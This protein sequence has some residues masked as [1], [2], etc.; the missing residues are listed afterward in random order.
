MLRRLLDVRRE[1]RRL[2][3]T[4]FLVLFGILAAHTILETARDALFLARLPPSQLPW[5]YLAMAAIAVTLSNWSTRRLHG[6]RALASL[7]AICSAGT[8][9]FWATGSPLGSWA[10]RALYV[11]TGLVSTLA[12]V[13]FWLVVS[14]LY[15]ITQAKRVYAVIGLGSLLGAVAGGGVAR[16]V[17][18]RVGA[19]HLLLVS[20]A[21]LAATAFGPATRLG[22]RGAT[23]GDDRAATGPALADGL[24]LIWRHPYLARLAGIVLIATL[25]VTLADYVFKSAVARAVPPAQLASFFASFYTVLNGLALAAQLFVVSWLMRVLGVNRALWVLPAFLFL[26][27]T[28][29]VGGGG[30]VA[31]LLLKGADGVLRPSL[32]RVGMELLFVPVPDHLRSF[33]K[34]TD[35]LGQRGGQALA[36]IFILGWL[37]GGRG[38]AVLA[39]ISALLCVVWIARTVNLNSHYLEIFRVALRTGTLKDTIHLP[40]LDMGALELLFSALNSQDD[41][42]VL[43]ALDLLDEEGRAQLV[44]ALILYHP[45]R[46]VV[47]RALNV[48]AKSGRV[49]FVPIA[50]RLIDSPDAEIRAAALRARS[51]VR[52]EALVLRRAA[53]D[54][55]PLVRATGIVGLIGGGWASDDARQ[56]MD[57]LVRS[58]SADT[59]VAVARA[60]ER[61]PAAE[62]EDVILQLAESPDT[63]VLRHVAHA[64]A[65]IKSPSFLPKLLLMLGQREIRNETRAALLQY[66]EEA[67]GMLDA[68]LGDDHMPRHVRRQIPHTIVQF[69]SDQATLVLQKH[70]LHQ[71]DGLVRFKILRA[72]GR[73]A[74]D[75]PEVTFDAAVLRKATERAIDDT[76]ELLYWR[77][78]LSRGAT[79]QP[80]RLTAGHSLIVLLLRDKERHAVE[81]IFRL[82]GLAFR[83]EDLRSIHRGLT[84]ASP[85]VRAGSRELLEN[86]LAP[87][88]RESVIGLV[89]DDVDE[90]RLATVRPD[91]ARAP[92]EYDAL[93]TLLGGG[94]RQTL[95]SLARYHA[96][97]IGLTMRLRAEIREPKETSV[98]A[99]RVL[100]AAEALDDTK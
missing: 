99:A 89:D 53:E 24:R 2:T 34:L 60:I 69:A 81:R 51:T 18:G 33:A 70:L 57:D 30:L 27:A 3:A 17:S 16:I 22:S 79:T 55:S 92:I 48:L 5:M 73:I 98:F 29:V 91:L 96:R 56:I 41:A 37:A 82:L 26:G 45:S 93:V 95:R 74:A 12:A 80:R 14:D 65:K 68:A 9:L 62:F 64:M 61:Q 32:H 10:L 63:V 21:V 15:T 90:R 50:D 35:V 54:S 78:N 7:L 83:R 43:G 66:G 85:K 23:R 94:R 6:P 28:G 38:D 19:H 52:P 44:P 75:H 59:Q 76:V 86:V 4:A 72:L 8:F 13:Q 25:A 88:L 20:A 46:G 36:S 31:A 47:F 67:L 84:N 71:S 100:E 1:E 42:E 49:D 40:A 58:S 97:E 87:P 11:W 77:I 39:I